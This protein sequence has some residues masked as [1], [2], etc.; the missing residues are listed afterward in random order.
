MQRLAPPSRRRMGLFC[1]LHPPFFGGVGARRNFGW[2]RVRSRLS[3]Q[4]TRSLCFCS[5]LLP[6]VHSRMRRG[7]AAFARW[8]LRSVLQRGEVEGEGTAKR[9]DISVGLCCSHRNKN[10]VDRAVSE[11]GSAGTA[12]PAMDQTVQAGSVGWEQA[13]VKPNALCCSGQARGRFG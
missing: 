11:N 2:R 4:P 9:R 5:N 1:I 3:P 7:D 10:P 12:T 6:R 8:R 13:Q